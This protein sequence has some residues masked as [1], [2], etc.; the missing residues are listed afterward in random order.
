MWGRLIT[1]IEACP[2]LHKSVCLRIVYSLRIS[3]TCRYVV[4]FDEEREQFEEEQ[5]KLF[6]FLHANK[7]MNYYN[8]DDSN[9]L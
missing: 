7:V 2:K 9:R 8:D 5:S 6:P 4:I 3:G 1:H